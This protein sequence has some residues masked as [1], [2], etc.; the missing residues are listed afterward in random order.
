[1]MERPMTT[2][3]LF[4]R[5]KIILK[6]KNKLPDILDYGLPTGNVLPIKT[7]DFELKSDLAYGTSGGIYLELWIRYRYE[8]RKST[9][10]NSSHIH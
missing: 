6:E 9:R 3:E 8:D 4:N 10:L 5:I 2:E 7:C 1:M